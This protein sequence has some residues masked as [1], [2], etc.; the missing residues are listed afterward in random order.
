MQ[1][2]ISLCSYRALAVPSDRRHCS[3]DGIEPR[4]VQFRI[5]LKVSA[6][7][8]LSQR[9]KPRRAQEPQD[10]EKK[11]CLAIIMLIFQFLPTLLHKGIL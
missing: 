7:D 11:I 10:P 2:D 9:S 6:M 1:V 8:G 4:L 3:R 5:A